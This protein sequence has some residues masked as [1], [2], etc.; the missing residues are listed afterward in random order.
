MCSRGDGRHVSSSTST[1]TGWIRRS[2]FNHSRPG[3]RELATGGL[4]D[5]Q[6]DATRWKKAERLADRVVI[7]DPRKQIV[8]WEAAS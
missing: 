1:P 5:C 8:A 4:V 6:A 2:A 7:I 3:R